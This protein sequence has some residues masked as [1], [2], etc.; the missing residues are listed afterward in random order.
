MSGFPRAIAI[1]QQQALH[2][3]IVSIGDALEQIARSLREVEHHNLALSQSTFTHVQRYV[4]AA[5]SAI[6][7]ARVELEGR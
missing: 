1:A 6:F 5:H 4:A 3:E 7:A 2:D